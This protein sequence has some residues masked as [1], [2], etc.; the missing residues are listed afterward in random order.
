MTGKNKN[1]H[2]IFVVNMAVGMDNNQNVD[3][4]P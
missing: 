3:I 2:P 4:Y 1:S